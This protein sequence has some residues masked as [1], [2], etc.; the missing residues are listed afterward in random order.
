[1]L[2]HEREAGR[3]VNE[4]VD[5]HYTVH[6]ISVGADADRDLLRAVAW[7]GS[8]EYLDVP[9]GSSV[10]EMEGQMRAAF[11]KIAAAA[12]APKLVSKEQ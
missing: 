1:M 10:A 7:L 11:A 6:A 3:L 5:K 8:G 4:A 2:H 9:G 12:P